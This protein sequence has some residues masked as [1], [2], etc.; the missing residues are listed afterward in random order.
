[1]KVRFLTPVTAA[2]ILIAGCHKSDPEPTPYDEPFSCYRFYT[3]TGKVLDSLTGTPLEGV[4]VGWINS[5]VSYN[6]W[7][8]SK[9]DGSYTVHYGYNPCSK[10]PNNDPSANP[11]YPLTT[12]QEYY[13]SKTFDFSQHPD[14]TVFHENIYAVP[15]SHVTLHITGTTGGEMLSIDGVRL[16]PTYPNKQ[17]ELGSTVDTL[18]DCK[19]FSNRT[20]SFNLFVDGALYSTSTFVSGYGTSGTLDIHYP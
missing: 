7:D 4:T 13:Y 3:F 20:T 19:V 9:I 12:Y 15:H 1:M 5:P 18:I 11:I 6:Y 10:Y 2:L 8:T 17:T 16:Y 14:G